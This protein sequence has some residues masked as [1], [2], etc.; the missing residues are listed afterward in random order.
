[1][2]R[3]FRRATTEDKIFYVI[4][5][6]ILTLFFLAVLYPCIYV[7]SASFS[8]GQAVN[9]GKVVFLPV[10]LSVE[11]YKTILTNKMVWIGFRNSVVYT[12]SGIAL[13]VFLTMN[14]AYALSRK[15]LV[16]RKFFTLLYTITMFFTGGLIPHYLLIS[17]LHMLNTIWAV[18]LP[19]A[20][21]VYN[22][23]VARTYIRNSIPSE[24]FEAATLDGCSDL[25]YYLKIILPLS[26]SVIAVLVLFYG[27]ATWNAY[28][29]P[30]L[31]LT[32]RNRF[33]I[34][35]YLRD[36]LIMGKVDKTNVSDP[37]KA[38]RM[39][40][41]AAGLKYSLIVV[42]TVPIMTLYPFIQKYFVKGVMIGSVKG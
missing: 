7:V 19:G 18:I 22:L 24:M 38:R 12:A 37:E 34:T 13:S 21:T 4:I 16:G 8:S 42:S 10:D 39:E 40:E 23:I 2:F 6:I 15:D 36:I 35:V 28:F 1:M 9:A 26:K 20:M 25:Q 11:G 41:M 31:Y 32:D 27:I 14:A 5:T 33:P 3:N 17:R 29:T 30:M